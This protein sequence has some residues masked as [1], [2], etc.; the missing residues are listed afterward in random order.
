MNVIRNITALAVV[1]G[2]PLIFILL[3]VLERNRGAMWRMAHEPLLD[4]SAFD[5]PA[6]QPAGK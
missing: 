2:V 1:V 5:P 4:K 6:T 3:I